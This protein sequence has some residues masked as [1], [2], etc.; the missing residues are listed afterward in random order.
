MVIDHPGPWQQYHLRS[1][2][3]NLS[4]M[5]L[6]AK[7]INE[8]YLFETQMFNSQQYNIFMNGGG[9]GPLSTS[10]PPVVITDPDALAFIAASGITDNTQ[11]SAI[12]SLV[13]SLKGYSVW[14]SLNAIYPFVGGTAFTHKWNLKDP[15]DL[16]AAY[17]LEF[18]GGW[19][20]NS[21]GITGNG[22]NALA[23][24][25]YNPST[26][27]MNSLGVYA[28]TGTVN[29]TFMSSITYNEGEGFYNGPYGIDFKTNIL[30]LQN[31]F[32]VGVGASPYTKGYIVTHIGGGT[33]TS[34]KVYR[35]GSDINS[36]HQPDIWQMSFTGV[37]ITIGA[38]REDYYDPDG[39]FQYTSYLNYTTANI[40][41][42]FMGNTALTATEAANLNTAMVAYQ[43]TLGRQV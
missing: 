12:N 1:D 2:N 39:I 28:R 32:Q 5:E 18:F 27:T 17:R 13:L 3:K 40:A 42:A 16:D 9:G 8:Q 10:T 38:R 37:P 36:T 7:Y 24:T 23:N 4:V 14:S 34:V 31:G 29:Q 11:K 25:F 21:N 33:T 6:K 22:T 41:F 20:H 43:T 30:E 35:N 19:T 26:N 15:R